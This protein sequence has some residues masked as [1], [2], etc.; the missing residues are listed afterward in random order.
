M[1]T[2]VTTQAYW[3]PAAVVVQTWT[4]RMLAVLS[5]R[6]RREERRCAEEER[7]QAIAKLNVCTR[8]EMD[9]LLVRALEARKLYVNKSQRRGSATR[10]RGSGSEDADDNAPEEKTAENQ[11]SP[12]RGSARQRRGS[13]RARAG[14]DASSPSAKK[15]R[16]SSA[17]DVPLD[18]GMYTLTLRM[19]GGIFGDGYSAGREVGTVASWGIEG[20]YKDLANAPGAQAFDGTR[21][22]KLFSK[23]RGGKSIL[24]RVPVTKLDIIFARHK[25]KDR[26]NLSFPQ[27]AHALEEAANIWDAKSKASKKKLQKR[28]ASAVAGAGKVM[29]AS[30][31][32]AAFKDAGAVSAAT[33]SERTA[34]TTNDDVVKRRVVKGGDTPVFRLVCNHVMRAKYARKAEAKL[35][36]AALQNMNAQAARMQRYFFMHVTGHK[37]LQLARVER[38]EY[39]TN[40]QQFA[41][42]QK[43]QI[44]WRSKLARKMLIAMINEMYVKYHD[45]VTGAPYYYNKVLNQKSWYKPYL[46]KDSED[47]ANEFHLPDKD[48]EFVVL[49][50]YCRA[51]KPSVVCAECE[52]PYCA[53]CFAQLHKAGARKSHTSYEVKVCKECDYQ[54]ATRK[55]RRTGKVYC[56]NCFINV[57]RKSSNAPPRVLE[58]GAALS[59]EAIFSLNRRRPWH[60]VVATCV[61]CEIYA[62]RWRCHSC[63]DLFCT[64]CFAKVHSKG[65]RQSHDCDHLPCQLTMLVKY[66][67]A[68][69]FKAEM[70]ER[71]R[72]RAILEAEKREQQSKTSALKLQTLW[73]ARRDRVA[74]LERMRAARIA[75]RKAYYEKK[76]LA[77]M[78]KDIGFRIKKFG[79]DVKDFFTKTRDERLQVL[80][81]GTVKVQNSYNIVYPTVDLRKH[82]V[83]DQKR[84]QIGDG[85]RGLKFKVH[86]AGA[87]VLTAEQIPLDA[88]YTGPSAEGVSIYLLPHIGRVRKALYDA[89]DRLKNAPVFKRIKDKFIELRDKIKD[90]PRFKALVAKGLEL[91]DKLA[92]KAKELM[93]KAKA[94]GSELLSKTKAH[95]NA[96]KKKAQKKKK[97]GS[98]PRGSPNRT[99]NASPKRTP[100][101]SPRRTPTGSP[102]R[103]P[104]GSPKR[105]PTGSP[106]RTPTGSPKRT[107]TGT[108]ASS[109]TSSPKISPR[110]DSPRGQSPRISPRRDSP[111]GGSRDNSPKGSPRKDEETV[112]AATVPSADESANAAVQ[113]AQYYDTDHGATSAQN[114]D[115]SGYDGYYDEHGQ[116]HQHAYT[117]Q[118]YGGEGQE[119]QYPG[120]DAYATDAAAAGGQAEEYPAAGDQTEWLEFFDD[121]SGAISCPRSVHAYYAAVFAPL[122]LQFCSRRSSL[123]PQPGNWRNDVGGPKV[124]LRSI[125]AHSDTKAF[126]STWHCNRVLMCISLLVRQ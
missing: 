62:C 116:Y 27:F 1:N 5:V 39:D 111:R 88:E 24:R 112:A 38:M 78:N 70:R 82:G 13:A 54:V 14:S 67:Q 21:W 110:R 74:G 6:R 108:P 68:K 66:K 53:E 43:I 59:P 122:T 15:N 92:S 93:A 47:V 17:S 71:A 86:V 16:R 9:R 105:T 96:A 3:T 22:K 114:Y 2:V 23:A 8:L 60:P 119:Y 51:D 7:V 104:T 50:S 61:E 126:D 37:L 79:H 30:A 56:D 76:A 49:C 48:T 98:S 18:G 29:A 35:S 42:A 106:K 33:G 123:L 124:V 11:R 4:R 102:R 72:K 103:T 90:D 85:K 81:P 52:D 80:L 40:K 77:E 64:K 100:T 95:F 120:Y 117:D 84:I 69:Q 41:A 65:S 10:R 107:P 87:D 25:D 34:A 12:R 57:F 20:V 83:E 63:E 94:K 46:L 32:A 89:V 97:K 109:S 31:A 73:R 101:G 45:P 36:D 26:R 75:K 58:S 121:A 91:K 115:E 125:M 28:L 19:G 118:A 113:E 99:P 44:F 55:D